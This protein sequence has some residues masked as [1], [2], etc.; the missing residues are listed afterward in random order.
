MT[1]H[2]PGL[3]MPNL[4]GVRPKIGSTVNGHPVEKKDIYACTVAVHLVDK[5]AGP[6]RRVPRQFCSYILVCM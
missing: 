2:F 3:E 5:V 6:V 4:D 1:M